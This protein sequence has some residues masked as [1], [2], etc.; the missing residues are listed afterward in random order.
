MTARLAAALAENAELL[1]ALNLDLDRMPPFKFSTPW[2]TDRVRAR[3][4]LLARRDQLRALAFEAS[5]AALE[6]RN[7]IG[8][9]AESFRIVR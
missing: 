2:H 6:A 8:T 5:F 4:G 1:A 7:P 9:I 3:E